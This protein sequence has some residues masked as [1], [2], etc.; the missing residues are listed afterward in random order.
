MSPCYNIYVGSRQHQSID[1]KIPSAATTVG[2]ILNRIIMHYQKHTP[3]AKLKMSLAKKGKHVSP[4]TEF[5]KGHKDTL[6]RIIALPRG[7]KHPRWNPKPTYSGVHQWVARTLG[8]PMKCTQCGYESDNPKTI[9]WANISGEYK[10]DVSDWIRLCASCHFKKDNI[11][12][13]SW[14]TRHAMLSNW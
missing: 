9:H 10:K 5:K 1:F 11:L 12:K 6:E 7:E 14:E 3:E 8:K 2:G 13:R 4:S